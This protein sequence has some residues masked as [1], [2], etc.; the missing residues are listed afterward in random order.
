MATT[1]ITTA[2]PPNI[3]I[4]KA[5]L[6]YGEHMLPKLNRQLQD[7]TLIT[8]QRALN[9]LC[10]VLHNPEHVS[11]ALKVGM[12]KSLKKLLGDSDGTVRWKA[13]EVL[14]ICSNHAIGRDAILEFDLIQPI[15]ALFD[16]KHED[17]RLMSHRAVESV[18]HT[19]NGAQ[20][21]VNA[22]LIKKLVEKLKTET[23]EIKQLVLDTLH[24]CMKVDTNQALAAQAMEVFTSLLGHETWEIRGKAA[25]DIMDISFPLEGKK[26]A[27]K[28][29][30]IPVLV[31]LLA[32]KHFHVRAQ[33]AG[34]LMS[35]AITTEGKRESISAG[36]VEALMKLLQSDDSS[37]VRLN[38][39]KVNTCSNVRLLTVKA[40]TMLAEAPSGRE[41]LTAIVPTLR[42]IANTGGPMM[43]KVAKTAINVITWQP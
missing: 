17:A 8:R 7:S 39:I 33:A 29:R 14:F 37:D 31:K 40:I 25:R 43:Q 24:Y 4:T 28:V 20:G 30:C 18:S 12:A 6:A 19:V 36:A 41:K 11:A 13:T 10:D 32:D 5:E 23:D 35:I 3:D 42:D 34:A 15:S 26:R 38:V 9:A 16:D 21:I 2:L 1:R 27:V 22:N